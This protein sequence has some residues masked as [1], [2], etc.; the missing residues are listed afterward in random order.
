MTLRHLLA[1]STALTAFA[2]LATAQDALPATDYVLPEITLLP[3][4]PRP[5]WAAPAPPSRW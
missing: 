1:A 3:I 2:G 5:N 4:R